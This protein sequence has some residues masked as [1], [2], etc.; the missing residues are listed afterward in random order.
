LKRLFSVFSLA[1]RPLSL[2]VAAAC[3]APALA[4]AQKAPAADGPAAWTGWLQGDMVRVLPEPAHTANARVRGELTGKGKLSSELKWKLSARVGYD[5]AYDNDYYLPGVR[6]DQRSEVSL[7]EAHVDWGR[8]DWELRLGRQHIVWGEMVGLFFADVVSAKDMRQFVLQDFEQLRIPQWAARVEYFKNDQHL[9][10]IW[11]PAPEYD[12]IGKPGADFYPSPYRYEGLGYDV[13]SESKLSRS[14]ANGGFGARYSTERSGWD[15]SAF[16]YRSPDMAPTFARE[17]VGLPGL[18]AGLGLPAL[19]SSATT[20]YRPTYDRLL[21][22]GGTLAKDFDGLVLKAE[23]VFTQGRRFSSLDL[24]TRNGLVAQ[25]T[26]DWVVGLEG[27]PAEGWRVNGQFFQ[28][29]YLNHDPVTGFK[30]FESGVS[31]LVTRALT[32]ALDAE[33]LAISSLLRSDWLARAAL[34][35][36]AGPNLRVKAGYDAFGGEPLGLFGRYGRQDRVYGQV[37]YTY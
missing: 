25:N 26:I 35:W 4:G 11:L 3:L 5:L 2:A 22:V 31:L 37:R 14:F 19:G 7:R 9:E 34:T 6:R 32:P 8:G 10:L 23:A 27:T 36:K 30:R 12:R 21:R 13:R 20:I 16:V 1:V 24:A 33:L 28:R 15:L 18:G 17:V 29:A